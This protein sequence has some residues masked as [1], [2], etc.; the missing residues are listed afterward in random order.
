MY[1]TEKG[2]QSTFLVEFRNLGRSDNHMQH[3]KN[4]IEVK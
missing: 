4:K 2:V 3:G 1:K